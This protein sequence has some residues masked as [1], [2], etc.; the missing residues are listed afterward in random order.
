M[1]TKSSVIVV[2]ILLAAVV[3]YRLYTR[4]PEYGTESA[5]EPG[6]ATAYYR[7][8]ADGAPHSGHRFGVARKS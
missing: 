7:A 1:S 8:E 6:F 5:A 4:G 2:V 3:V